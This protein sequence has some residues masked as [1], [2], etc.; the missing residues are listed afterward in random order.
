MRGKLVNKINKSI[1]IILKN[2]YSL[3]SSHWNNYN[4]TFPINKSTIMLKDIVYNENNY[5]TL[6]YIK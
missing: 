3:F 5:Y 1:E 4:W 2:F 6:K